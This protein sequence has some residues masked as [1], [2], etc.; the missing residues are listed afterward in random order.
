MRAASVNALDW[1]TTHGGLLLEIIGK[2]TRSK[3]QPIRGVDLAGIV[4][5]VGPGVTRLKPGDEVFGSAGATFA[6]Y[7]RAREERRH[8]TPSAVAV[9]QPATAHA[10]GPPPPP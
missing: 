4:V 5:E 3:D 2:F 6:E 10:H 9:E 8:H 7:V 1:H